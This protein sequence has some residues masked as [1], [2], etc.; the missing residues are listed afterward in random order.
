LAQL[1][2]E[3]DELRSEF[4]R[5]QLELESTRKTKEMAEKWGQQMDKS[6][7]EM[8][9]QLEELKGQQQKWLAEIGWLNFNLQKT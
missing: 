8:A 7:T 5:A 4:S 3:L 6:R 2:L 9:A 1:D